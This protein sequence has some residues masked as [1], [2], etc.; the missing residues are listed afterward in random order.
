M[1]QRASAASTLVVILGLAAF[2]WIILFV[3]PFVALVVL[4][5]TL[6]AISFF[7]LAVFVGVAKLALSDAREWWRKRRR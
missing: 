5:T 4:A 1:G 7:F 3:A 2:G 6:V